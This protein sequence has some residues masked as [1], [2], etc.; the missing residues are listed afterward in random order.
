VHTLDAENEDL[1]AQLFALR[2]QQQDRF[3]RPD[4]GFQ[5]ELIA[6]GMKNIFALC[7]HMPS[8]C[9]SAGAGC[10][11]E[12]SLLWYSDC[13]LTAAHAMQTATG[14][15]CSRR[16]WTTVATTHGGGCDSQSTQPPQQV[17]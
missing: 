10:D 15:A 13:A 3:Q 1:Q 5:G 16:L 4:R 7:F 6:C 2:R 11:I 12:L 14:N 9:H 8:G 17:V